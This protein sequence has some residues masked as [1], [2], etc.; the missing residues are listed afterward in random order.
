MVETKTIGVLILTFVAIIVVLSLF[1]SIASNVASVTQTQTA[2]NAT[3]TFPTA[4]NNLTLNGQSVTIT[5]VMNKSNNT[6]P[7]TSTNWTVYN[8]QVSNGQ[9]ISYINGAAGSK[10]AGQPVNIT[11]VY[12]PFG[13]DTSAGNRSIIGLVVILAALALAAYVIAQTY[14][15][16]I[17]DFVKG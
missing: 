15:D 9:L 13:Y 8:R 3:V 5:Y 17:S 1:P 14:S 7:L 11:Y 2:T 16:E 12:E 10:Y 4:G 6:D